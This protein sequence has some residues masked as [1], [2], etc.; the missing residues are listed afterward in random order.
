MGKP[1]IA[2][3]YYLMRIGVTDFDARIEFFQEDANQ[4]RWGENMEQR[5]RRIFLIEKLIEEHQEYRG[6][7]IPAQASE[8]K[9]LLR[10]LF[11]IRQPG[12]IDLEFLRVQ[13]EYLKE[14]TAVKGI[15]DISELTP[16]VPDIYLWQGDITTIRCDA[17][18][19]A[20]NSG[21]TGCYA[22]CHGCIDNCIHTFAG[23]QLRN[24]CY[25]M[26]EK[27]GH[28]EPTGQ[29]KI[30]PGFNLPCKYILHTVGPIIMDHVTQKDEELLASCYL[31]CLKVAESNHVR[32]IAFCC[33]S[34][35]EFH[36][37]NRGA[38][39]IAVHTV[40]AYKKS[41]NSDIKVIFN[42]WKDI[43]RKIY[44]DILN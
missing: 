35:G 5:E 38:A 4:L 11:N 30:T 41:T 10:A 25:E 18:V 15:T 23:I 7:E 20:A 27:Q 14:E 21:M 26:M 19:N 8:Q 24:Y 13:D 1:D 36:F 34:T 33:I 22:P 3:E 29:A 6:L 40:Q 12:G 28:A 16:I 2:V 44:R 9:A 17:I 42:V 39:E 43:D 32:H 37:P 31:S